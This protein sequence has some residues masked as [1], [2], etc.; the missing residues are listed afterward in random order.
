MP[1]DPSIALGYRPTTQLE[2]PSNQLAKILGIQQAQQALQ[3][4]E[5][6]M[7][8]N[9]MRFEEQQRGVERGNRLR[10]LLQGMGD[11]TPEQ[12]IEG[13]RKTGEFLSEADTMEKGFL[14]RRKAES[15]VQKNRAEAFSKLGKVQGELAT[16]VF[17]N[18]SMESAEAAVNAM[19]F[20]YKQ[21]GFDTTPIAAERQLL[22]KMTTPEQLKQWAA[23]HAL[24]AE[25]MLPASFESDLGGAKQFGTVNPLT[26]A[27]TVLGTNAKTQTPDSVA[28]VAATMRGQ[29][30]TDARAREK[31]QIDKDA[32][33]KVEWKQ[34]VDGN[35]I[36]LPK[37]VTG[38]GPVTPIAV[39]AQGKRATQAGQAV[40][41]INQAEKLI[42]KATSS[43][44][45]AGIDQAQ[46]LVGMSNEGA[47]AAAQLKALE[48]ALM[49]AQPRMEG[50]QSNA[51][52]KL[53]EQMAGQIGNPTVPAAQKKAA[54]A[55]IKELHQRYA[56]KG[57]DVL[58][59][60]GGKPSGAPKP[61][62][63][64]DGYR[65]KGGNPSDKTSWEKL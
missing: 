15:D 24:S 44:I 4:G 39:N 5:Q 62:D 33:A 25:K 51:D 13:L 48:G 55:T 52:V 28:S 36:A 59:A 61:G 63:V 22:A 11:A 40:N 26:G 42:D 12:R 54:L 1:I 65:F 9:R 43:Y 32:A 45:G 16:R 19:E 34:D 7:Q 57:A 17:A 41:I 56:P 50:P 20:A 38:Q 2:D 47:Q 8:A 10:S 6:A 53:Y 46:R 37:E 3:S 29:N 27:R 21:L 23:G 30:M 60:P 18:P 35:W 49:M 14:E 64:Q 58:P 31:N